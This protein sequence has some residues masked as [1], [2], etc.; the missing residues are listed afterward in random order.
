[1]RTYTLTNKA[2]RLFR[3]WLLLAY[4]LLFFLCGVLA[5]FFF[6]AAAIA[7]GVL[8]TLGLLVW[9]WYLPRL[10]KSY[11]VV[12]TDE[13]VTM[14]RGF[15]IRRQ[16][17]LPCPRLIY[18]EK[19]STPLSTLWGLRGLRLRAARGQLTIPALD[20]PDV[21][22]FLERLNQLGRQARREEN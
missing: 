15:F 7:A 12:F 4:L 8:L 14:S 22:D 9:F 18:A 13:A 10:V 16:Y 5:P 3:A 20:K 1:M 2:L 11:R 21:E 17:L 6:T 19:F